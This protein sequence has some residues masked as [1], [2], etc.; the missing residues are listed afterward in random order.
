MMK[1]LT[2]MEEIADQKTSPSGQSVPT[3]HFSLVMEYVMTISKI[4]QSAIMMEVIAVMALY[5][6][7][8]YA[9]GST[10]LC[11]QT[12]QIIIKTH[13]QEVMEVLIWKIWNVSF[14]FLNHQMEM[15][16][17]GPKSS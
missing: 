3:I 15:V 16:G 12:V 11:L 13:A 5:G 10:T 6:E 2:M 1:I 14:Q 9:M 8:R 4:N 17:F 7:I